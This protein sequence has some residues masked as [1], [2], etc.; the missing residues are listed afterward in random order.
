MKLGWI[1]ESNQ[2]YH[3]SH[4]LSA[5]GVVSMLQSPD[6]FKRGEKGPSK[7]AASLGDLVHAYLLE[8]E[9]FQKNS[10]VL[11]DYHWTKKGKVQ[12]KKFFEGL[13]EEDLLKYDVSDI[14]DMKKEDS[15]NVYK[16][17]VIIVK[18]EELET[19]KRIYENIANSEFL[20]SLLVGVKEKSGYSELGDEFDGIVVKCRP[21]VKNKDEKRE[22]DIKTTCNLSTA[23]LYTDLRKY[24]YDVKGAWYLD[25]SNGLDGEG[26][27]NEFIWF[28]IEKNPPWG[29]MTYSMDIYSDMYE[30]GSELGYKALYNYRDCIKS[31]N[32]PG[33]EEKIIKIGDRKVYV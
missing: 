31:G 1:D 13:Q 9:R 2:E 10:I 8:P 4:G 20:T 16:D 15:L 29:I 3:S 23:F 12:W 19:C 7:E 22:V 32:W 28:V 26:T 14:I 5:S 17:H 24:K 21:D 25:V 30:N 11:P 6:H 33:Y 27:Y 18:N